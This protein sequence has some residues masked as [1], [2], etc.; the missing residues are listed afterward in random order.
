MKNYKVDIV[1]GVL[2]KVPSQNIPSWVSSKEYAEMVIG[3]CFDV[4]FL[5]NPELLEVLAQP[6]LESFMNEILNLR[7]IN[8]FL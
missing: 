5:Y 8:L 1:P 2:C 6:E 3:A 4:G 7:K